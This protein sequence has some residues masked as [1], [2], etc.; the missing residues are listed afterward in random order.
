MSKQVP[1]VKFV[2]RPEK[3]FVTDVGHAGTD[4]HFVNV[5]ACDIGQQLG[6]VRVIR[7][8]EHRLFEFSEVNLDNFGVLRVFIGF[9]QLGLVQPGL[10]FLD[11]T[12]QGALVGIAVGNH[13]FH[14]HDIAG[15]VFLDRCGIQLDGAT[16]G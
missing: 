8:A 15:Q 14:E 3:E 13:V 5:G 11:A 6:V 9:E 7:E 12:L 4:K 16:S 10:H 1:N 2:T